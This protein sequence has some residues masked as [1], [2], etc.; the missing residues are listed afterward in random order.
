MRLSQRCS[1]KSRSAVQ[2]YPQR[3]VR[4]SDQRQSA[5]SSAPRE[6]AATKRRQ[7]V[8]VDVEGPQARRVTQ[9]ALVSH[10]GQHRAE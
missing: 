4:V 2:Q 10:Q 7:R 6:H 3:W 5:E 8:A 9:H 1:E